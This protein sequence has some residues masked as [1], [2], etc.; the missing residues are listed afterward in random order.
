MNIAAIHGYIIGF[1]IIGSWPIIMFWSLALRLTKHED[2]PTFWKAVSVAQVLL[3]IQLLIGLFLLARYFIGWEGAMLPGDQSAFETTFHLLY[4]AGFPLIVLGVAHRGARDGR[5]NPHAAFA[6][7][8]LVNFGLT[9][10]A[11]M[12]GAGFGG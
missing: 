12:V 4:G 7:V 1:A 10:R 11:W 6:V 2:T 9:A 8:G 5:F 3:G